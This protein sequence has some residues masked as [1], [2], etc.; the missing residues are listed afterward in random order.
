[1]S[2]ENFAGSSL[3][4]TGLLAGSNAI[5]ISAST[6]FGEYTG[7][8]SGLPDFAGYAAL[9]NDPGRWSMQTT[10]DFA[11]AAPNMT[12]F[13]LA[14]VPE[15]ETYALLLAGLGLVGMRL[16]RQRRLSSAMAIAPAATS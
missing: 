7:T 3:A 8:R 13:T 5:A 10:G 9:V 14:P 4:G 15:P 16:S 12:A 6:D 1:M 11:G 2:S